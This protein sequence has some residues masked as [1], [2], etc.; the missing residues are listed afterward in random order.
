VASVPGLVLLRR[1]RQPIAPFLALAF[2]VT[3][4]AAISFGVQRYRVP[5]DTVMPVLAAVALESG[6]SRI[7]ARSTTAAEPS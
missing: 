7:R 3:L 5:F 6:W 1:R 2:I 4:S